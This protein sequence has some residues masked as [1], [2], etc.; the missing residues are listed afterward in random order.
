MLIVGVK[1]KAPAEI[2]ENDEP[3]TSKEE[4]ILWFASK[5]P[6][7]KETTE[8][9]PELGSDYD[10]A[11]FF[12]SMRL[13]HAAEYSKSCSCKENNNAKEETV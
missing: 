8:A 4:K 1:A 7:G 5:Y 9:T 3:A 13:P 11:D 10:S 6:G 12:N 2:S